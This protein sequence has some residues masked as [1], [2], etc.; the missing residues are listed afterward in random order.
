MEWLTP[1]LIS[2]RVWS[3]EDMED[4]GETS[5]HDDIWVAAKGRERCNFSEATR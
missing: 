2:L 3:E 1:F 5:N 4:E